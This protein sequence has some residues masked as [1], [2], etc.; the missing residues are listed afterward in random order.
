LRHWTVRR[1]VVYGVAIAALLL[2]AAVA[3]EWRNISRIMFAQSMFGGG[4]QLKHF[5]RMSSIFPGHVIHRS[6]KPYEFM[7]GTPV[8]LPK[9]FLSAGNSEDTGR[10]L[11]ATDTTGLLIL[12]DDRVIFEQYWLGNTAKTRWPAWSV[13]KSFTSALVGIAIHDGKIGGIEDPITK[14]VPELKG[15]AYDGVRIKDALQMSSGAR[16]NEDYSDSQS[17]VNRFGRA[18]AL[19]GSLDAFAATLTRAVPPGTFNRYNS[20]DAQVLG[21]ILRRTT[22]KTQADYLEEKLWSP[23]GMES[24]AYWITD[25][26]GVEFAAG[27]LIASLRDF[28]KLGRLYANGGRWNEV[29]IVPADWVHASVSPDAPHLMPG[30]RASSDSAWGYGFQWWV[31]DDSGAFSAVGIYN[32]FIYVNPALHLVIAKTSANHT[33]GLKNDE[34]SDREDEHIAFFKAIERGL[35]AD[36]R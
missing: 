26:K 25:D 12:K 15:S 10:F 5:R 36:S 23:L 16:W 17:D 19:G 3:L 8:S 13:S 32:Q 20:M 31:P 35:S 4:D 11:A 7:R 9:S 6:A 27:G 28:A 24:D 14:Y 1:I 2:S 30:K 18:F 34:S 29:Q 21:M 33:Y 22:G